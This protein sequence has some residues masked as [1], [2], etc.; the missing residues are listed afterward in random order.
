LFVEGPIDPEVAVLGVRRKAGGTLMGCLMNFACH[1]AHHGGGTAFSA[2]FPGVIARAL[3][4]DGCP[5]TLY[6]NGASGNVHTSDPSRGGQDLNM[7]CAG[8][9]LAETARRVLG[10]L[11]YEPDPELRSV[12]RS[13]RLPFRRVTEEEIRG[14]VHGAQRFIDSG[15]YDRD[16]P[17]LLEKIRREGTSE[18]E[19][20]ALSI[21]GVAFVGIPAEFFVELGLRI[22]EHTWPKHTLVVSCANGMIGYVPTRE[23]FQRGGYETTFGPGSHMAPET[24]D[25]LA[26]A[27][28]E[29]VRSGG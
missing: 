25:L 27:A 6:L 14:T 13:L 26:E 23:A 19:V 11:R 9:L 21:G 4:S 18:A 1:L 3:K 12:S 24:G 20:Q 8:G 10:S 22:K 16:I 2:G 28:I 5:V 17:D 15:L 7:E 29:L